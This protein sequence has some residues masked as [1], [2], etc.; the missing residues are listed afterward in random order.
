MIRDI[1]DFAIFGFIVYAIA[2]AV[3]A[4]TS[5]EAV[6]QWLAQMDVAYDQTWMEYIADCDCTESL[7]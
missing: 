3:W 5:P 4:R 2:V 7:E 6:G 1:R